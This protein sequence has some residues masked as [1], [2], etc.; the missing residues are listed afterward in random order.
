[1][2]EETGSKEN[3]LLNLQVV[4]KWLLR[5][6]INVISATVLAPGGMYYSVVSCYQYR[7][8]SLSHMIACLFDFEG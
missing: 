4:L 6:F 2:Q 7:G 5:Y 3:V 1:M 8:V